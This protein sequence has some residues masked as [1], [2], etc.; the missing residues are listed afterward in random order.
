[1]YL[2]I[3]GFYVAFNTVQVISR[4]VVGRAEETSTYSWSIFCTVNCRPTASNYQLSNLRSGQ[5][6]NPDLRGGGGGGGGGGRVLP[7]CQPW[8]PQCETGL[9]WLR[10]LSLKMSTRKGFYMNI[11][12]AVVITPTIFTNEKIS[13]Q[14]GLCMELKLFRKSGGKLTTL[15]EGHKITTLINRILIIRKQLTFVIASHGGEEDY[16]GVVQGGSHFDHCLFLLFLTTLPFQSFCTKWSHWIPKT[17]ESQGCWERE[18]S[19]NSLN[20]IKKWLTVLI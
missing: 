3:W 13:Q 18:E 14:V 2:F 10:V 5:E 6:P 16:R 12:I 9:N 17:W 19:N 20:I 4:R 11:T 1:M 15:L 8:P 7:L